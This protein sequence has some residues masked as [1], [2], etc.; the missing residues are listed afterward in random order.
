MNAKHSFVV[1]SL[2]VGI[3]VAGCGSDPSKED[4]AV[5]KAFLGGPMPKGFMEKNGPGAGQAAGQKAAQ[6]AAAKAAAAHA[7]GG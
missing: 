7:G 6:E 4:P 5:K 1:I 3:F 2:A